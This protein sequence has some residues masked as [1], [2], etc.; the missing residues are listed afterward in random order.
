MKPYTSIFTGNRNGGLAAVVVTA[1]VAVSAVVITMMLT[2]GADRP[3]EADSLSA[4]VSAIPQ[5]PVSSN[6]VYIKIK[7]NGE[8]LPATSVFGDR[9]G[10]WTDVLEFNNSVTVPAD[11]SS[12]LATG[13]RQHSPIVFTKRIDKASPVLLNAMAQNEVIEL[14]I[15]FESTAPDGSPQTYYKI[16]TTEGRITGIRKNMG[17]LGGDTETISVSIGTITESQEIDGTQAVVDA[18]LGRLD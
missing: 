6:S 2:N 14:T 9:D 18:L 17:L 16:E 10:E 8:D 4:P 13:R 15:E 5:D 7:A 3:A 12:G 1:I 11:R